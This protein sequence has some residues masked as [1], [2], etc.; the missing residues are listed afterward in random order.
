M[1]LE[2]IDVKTKTTD[3]G[4]NIQIAE[5]GHIRMSP[6]V[7]SNILPQLDSTFKGRRCVQDVDANHKVS[8][9]L[10]I[11]FEEIQ[12]SRGRLVNY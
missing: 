7:N 1:N 11:G 6:S 4:E 2:W 9:D 3:L 8:N 10:V 5:R 12:Q